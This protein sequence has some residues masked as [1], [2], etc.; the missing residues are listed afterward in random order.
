[1]WHCGETCE[2]KPSILCSCGETCEL[3]AS[4]MYHCGETCESDSDSDRLGLVSLVSWSPHLCAI[5]ESLW[6][7]A[8]IYVPLWWDSDSDSDRLGLVS[9]VSWS[10]HLC[11]IAVRLMSWSSHLC[12]IE[13]LSVLWRALMVTLDCIRPAGVVAT[14][15]VVR[16]ICSR[17]ACW[18]LEDGSA[19]S[20]QSHH[21]IS[22][23]N[24][25]LDE[26][27][28][29]INKKWDT[30]NTSF[31]STCAARYR[32]IYFVNTYQFVLYNPLAT[33]ETWNTATV[34]MYECLHL[35]V[36]VSDKRHDGSCFFL[37]QN[38]MLSFRWCYFPYWIPSI[39]SL[40]IEWHQSWKQIWSRRRPLY[41]V[42]VRHMRAKLWQTVLF[43][44]PNLIYT[45]QMCQQNGTNSLCIVR[46]WGHDT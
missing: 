37:C 40:Q 33:W 5:A 23:K 17:N 41:Q 31:T 43:I 16:R 44:S 39:F 9:L 2:L 29:F 35:S 34:V 8:L 14:S 28:V 4:S 19:S 25:P 38:S 22:S 18:K 30:T 45:R 6:V 46:L 24:V 15:R 12:Y 3:K 21:L 27:S 1:M 26:E 11:A 10:P 32:S 36:T 20:T 13:V 7:E 42:Y